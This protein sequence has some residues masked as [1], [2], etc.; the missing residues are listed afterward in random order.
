MLSFISALFKSRKVPTNVPTRSLAEAIRQVD[1]LDE[2]LPEEVWPR[3]LRSR[4]AHAILQTGWDSVAR[5]EAQDLRK[6]YREFAT[7]Y[8][9]LM[10]EAVD[11]DILAEVY[12]LLYL[13]IWRQAQVLSDLKP[14][15]VD[16]VKPFNRFL[17]L[18]FGK[19]HLR[20]YVWRRPRIAYLTESNDLD[21]GNAVG[22]ITVSLM[23]GQMS[24]RPES[25]WPILYCIGE[26]P[27]AS[28]FSFCDRHALVAHNL[29]RPGALATVSAVLD[30]CANDDIDILVSDHCGAI[31]TMIFQRGAAR[32][33]AF[34]EN[35]FAAWAIPEL[36]AV[37]L[38]IT[39]SGQ[40]LVEDRVAVT[41]TPRNTALVFQVRER[42]PSDIKALRAWIQAEAGTE[43]ISTLFGFYGRMSKVTPAYLG[44]VER[45]LSALPDSVFFVGGSGRGEEVLKFKQSSPAGSRIVI[46]NEFVDGHIVAEVLDVFLDTYPFPGGMSC[47]EVQARG[48]PV[49]WMTNAETERELAI[50]ADQRDPA[51][52][53]TDTDMFVAHALD[54]QNSAGRRV[55][56]DRAIEIARRFSDVDSEAAEVERF[57]H[58]LWKK[59]K[60]S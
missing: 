57:F 24:L 59:A 5:G 38:G 28:L 19:S 32:L 44:A 52:K 18:H 56:K 15:N 39:K 21:Y 3:E 33:Q 4:V 53:S 16:V 31:A 10:C 43:H 54:L 34:H 6:L 9:R 7:L 35:G 27:Q 26:N 22:R 41:R 23:I 25:E 20:P 1:W 13:M 17:N 51:L 2:T 48:I 42:S 60:A 8:P 49:V 29:R 36:D 47:I 14:F 12:S 55:Y 45:I 46:K 40:G 58:A 11:V 50:I 37:L 30:R